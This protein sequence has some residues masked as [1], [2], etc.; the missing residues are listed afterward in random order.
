MSTRSAGSH[1]GV[2]A[3]RRNQVELGSK[4]NLGVGGAI[5]RGL[6]FVESHEDLGHV[7]EVTVERDEFRAVFHRA[8]RNP[9]V[10]GR[11][12]LPHGAQR[13]VDDGVALCGR[14]TDRNEPDS[15]AVAEEIKL[16]AVSS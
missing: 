5:S 12:G 4:T 11:N 9:Q 13:C 2:Q 10:V 16:V 3:S 7:C 14:L 6:S 8:C 15:R 1:V